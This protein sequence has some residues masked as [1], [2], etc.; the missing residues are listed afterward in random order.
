VDHENELKLK[1]EAGS[2]VKETAQDRLDK[3]MKIKSEFKFAEHNDR[4]SKSRYLFINTRFNTDIKDQWLLP[5]EIFDRAEGD[6]D[7]VDTARRALKKNLSIING[8]TIISKIP[9]S[10]YSFKYP[11]KLVD[12]IG[13]DGAQVFFLKAN[14]DRPDQSVQDAIDDTKHSNLKWLCRDEAYDIVHKVYMRKF[15][16]G[17]LHEDKVRIERIISRAKDYASKRK[18]SVKTS[19]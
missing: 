1:S 6:R 14:L 4:L 15:D 5:Q 13:Y 7:L 3:W 8:F 16:Q 9:S 17:L 18:T 12:S 10:C 2:L 19:V 11:K